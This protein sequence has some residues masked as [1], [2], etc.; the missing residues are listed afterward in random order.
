[1]TDTTTHQ[2]VADAAR[3]RELH[4]SRLREVRAV[5]I[6]NS[7]LADTAMLAVSILIFTLIP[8]LRFGALLVPAFLILGCRYSNKREPALRKAAHDY[9]ILLDMSAAS[10]DGG[11]H[12]RRIERCANAAADFLF[13]LL[14]ASALYYVVFGAF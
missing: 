11:S 4:D 10:N 12:F 14:L 2:S 1:M 9:Y 6:V 3:R 13:C 5:S 7:I 8:P